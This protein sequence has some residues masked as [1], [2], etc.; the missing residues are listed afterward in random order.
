MT[1]DDNRIQ[2]GT[3]DLLSRSEAASQFNSS[4]NML[5]SLMF[6]VEVRL[7][8]N[9]HTRCVAMQEVSSSDL[10]NLALS[11][12]SSRGDGPEP[13]LHNPAIVMGL[14]EESLSTPATAEQKGPERGTLVRGSIRSQKNM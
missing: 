13:L 12:K 7:G 2:F 9:D 14:T 1:T 3:Q 4:M 5:P 10:A 11:K 8:E 6:L